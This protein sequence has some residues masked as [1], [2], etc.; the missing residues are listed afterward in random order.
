VREETHLFSYFKLTTNRRFSGLSPLPL[1]SPAATVDNVFDEKEPPA[2][3]NDKT[4]ST[5]VSYVC[6]RWVVRYVF[7]VFM[8]QTVRKAHVWVSSI[9]RMQPIENLMEAISL[10]SKAATS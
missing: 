10:I 9:C 6:F 3:A 4:T 5:E 7:S 1:L 2:A 8:K